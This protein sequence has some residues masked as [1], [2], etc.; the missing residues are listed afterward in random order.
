MNILELTDLS[1][2]Y[3]KEHMVIDHLNLN[4]NAGQVIGLLGR[5]GQGKST[6][7]DTI[8]AIHKCY[9]GT[10]KING[11]QD[12]SSLEVK[13]MRYYI[14]DNPVLF[15]E[16]SPQ[17]YFLLLHNLYGK[18]FDSKKLEYY[19]YIFQFGEYYDKRISTLSLGNR[20]KTNIIG[21][22]M[23]ETPLLILDEPLNGLDI[24]SVDALYNELKKYAENGN[25][26]IFSTHIIEVLPQ[27][28]TDVAI[29]EGHYIKKYI[30]KNEC[31]N[32]RKEFNEVV[33]AGGQQ[34]EYEG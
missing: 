25:A 17:K 28:C 21:A 9:K 27:V 30:K 18:T 22:L 16:I 32:L 14:Q 4:V 6:L 12:V 10:I 31:A 2:W 29:L 33:Q 7:L 1:I 23:L 20:K 15:E 5:N 34:E 3:K 19:N 26:V 13:K 11:L 24:M 8:S